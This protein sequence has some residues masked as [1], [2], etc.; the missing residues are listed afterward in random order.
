MSH[1]V[2]ILASRPN[3]AI[4]IGAARNLRQRMEQHKTAAVRGHAQRYKIS[5]LVYF[6]QYEETLEALHRERKLKRWRRT[7]KNEL[8][9]QNNPHWSD[10]SSEIPL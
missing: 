6:E 7:W 1:F 8:I 9:E 5:T 4:Y 10:V 3:G 2:Y